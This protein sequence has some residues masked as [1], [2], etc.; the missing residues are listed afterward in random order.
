MPYLKE[1]FKDYKI[2][3][4]SKSPRR[5]ALL[6]GLEID[7]KIF[8]KDI[9]ESYPSHL[10]AVEIAEY[11][12]QKK[13]QAYQPDAD[14]ILLTSDTIVWHNNKVLEKPKN[15]EEAIKMLSELSGSKHQVISAVTIRSST[16]IKTVHDIANVV[17][18]PLS[19]EEIEHYVFNYQ[20]FDKAGGY[21]IQEWIGYVG[22][23]KIEGSHYTVMGL[24]VH[25]VYQLLQELPL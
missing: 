13:A 6:K 21:G 19:K 10:Q 4:A 9:D 12:S 15:P 1:K 20:P 25:K 11:L 17:F 14:E 3:L 16:F 2:I 18:R 23:E 7:F 22:I 24:P 8:T 5:S